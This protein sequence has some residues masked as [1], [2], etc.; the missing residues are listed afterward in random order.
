M[1]F[2]VR[3][4]YSFT[5]SCPLIILNINQFGCCACFRSSRI[6]AIDFYIVVPY[7][8]RYIA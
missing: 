2:M 8:V 7:V 5:N 3:L 1:N 6:E 4:I